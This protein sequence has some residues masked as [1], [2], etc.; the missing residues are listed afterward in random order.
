M[1]HFGLA[2]CDP[3]PASGPFAETALPAIYNVRISVSKTNQHTDRM[4]KDKE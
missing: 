1:G 2:F 3:R 4:R